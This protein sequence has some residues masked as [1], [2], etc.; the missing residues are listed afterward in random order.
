[1]S[2]PRTASTAREYT[3]PSSTTMIP[4]LLVVD[5]RDVEEADKQ[6]RRTF[7]GTG[8]PRRPARRTTLDEAVAWGADEDETLEAREVL[9]R[10]GNA[11]ALIVV[12]VPWRPDG[13]PLDWLD[14]DIIAALRGSVRLSYVSPLPLLPDPL[15]PTTIL[16]LCPLCG[17][18]VSKSQ[19][20]ALVEHH[21]RE[22]LRD[23][24]GYLGTSVEMAERLRDEVAEQERRRAISTDTLRA[25]TEWSVD[26]FGPQHFEGVLDH[27]AAELDEVGENPG[28]VMEWVDVLLLA[29][30][31]A[32]R[33]GHAPDNL[34]SAFH[35][36][37]EVNKQRE[38]PDWRQADPHRRIEH[39]REDD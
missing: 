37:I 36:K 31:G 34:L 27:L 17:A 5:E 13:G 14:T 39:I 16:H 38:W 3:L 1:M 18:Q 6:L 11:P 15:I 32:A 10:Q 28:D 25:L 29:F 22:H 2:D 7:V 24:H 19:S 21:V 30:D 23:D 12:E 20:P 35:A 33:A 4:V 26:T 9:Q 8:L